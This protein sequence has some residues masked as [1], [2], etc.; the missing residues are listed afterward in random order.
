M[1]SKK[2]LGSLVVVTPALEILLCA[3]FSLKAPQHLNVP[4]R[5]ANYRLW[6]E[7]EALLHDVWHFW[8]TPGGPL[9]QASDSRLAFNS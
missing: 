4:T 8:L 5:K 9:E 6:E 3:P 1:C 2:L 7:F